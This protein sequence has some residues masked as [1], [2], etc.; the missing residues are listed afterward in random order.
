[1]NYPLLIMTA[2]AGIGAVDVFYYY[3][4]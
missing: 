2:T 3:L 1:M 4:S